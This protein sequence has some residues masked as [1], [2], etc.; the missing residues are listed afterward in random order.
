MSYKS[1]VKW[2]KHSETSLTVITRETD[3]YDSTNY[4][5]KQRLVPRST[6]TVVGT[7]TPFD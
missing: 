7:I 5:I 2:D 3:G 4:V 6:E 1:V